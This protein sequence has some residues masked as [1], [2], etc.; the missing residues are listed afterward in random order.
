MLEKFSPLAV[1]VTFNPDFN[2]THKNIQNLNSNSVPVLVV[3]NRSKNISSIRSKIGKQNVLIENE[4]NL[5]LGFALNRGIEYAQTNRY[6]H[7]WLFDQ[8]SF[9]ETSAIRTFLQKVG[10]YGIQ[11]SRNEKIA[12]FGPNIFDT[13]KDRNI[14][15]IRENESGILNVEFLITSG[16]F[17][18]LDVF[19]DVGLIYQDFFIDYLDYEW[20]FR[21]NYKGY[22]HKIVSKVKMNHSIGNDSRSILGLFKVAIHSPFRWYFL[23]RNG[24]Y[25]CRMSHIP[26]R[27]KLEVVFK[28]IFRFL[29]LPIF[30]NSKYQTYRH[31]LWGIYDGVTKKQSSFYKHLVGRMSQS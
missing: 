14:Y 12:S 15:R 22:V 24:I 8:D 6:T 25:M 29:I 30:S 23:F 31:I 17:Y 21:A 20:C 10:E 7:V 9:L 16:S 19:R 13:I 27:F 18:S 2:F 26:L 11:K 4:S 5:G 3:D 1:I 28:A